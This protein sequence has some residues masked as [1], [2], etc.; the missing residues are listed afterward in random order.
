MTV[1]FLDRKQWG[2]HP[3]PRLG[4]EVSRATWKE[5]IVHHTAG[6]R[7]GPS[8]NEWDSFAEMMEVMRGLQTGRPDLGL[9][10]PYNVVAFCRTN[11]ELVLCEGRGLDRTGAHTSGK[12]ATALGVGFAGDFELV[13]EPQ[14]LDSQLHDLG[15]WLFRAHRDLGLVNLGTSCPIDRDAWGH[16]E[17]ANT[18][19]PGA[20][21][22]G[23]LNLIR[24]IEEETAMD[25]ATWQIVQ[26]GLQALDPPLYAGR[27]VDGIPGVNTDRAVRAFEERMG[28]N[29][30][31]V[32]GALNNPNAGMW[33]ATRELL[34]AGVYSPWTPDHEH[35]V[36][37]RV[38][39]VKM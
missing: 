28:L 35:E 10:V 29:P 27:P 2:A 16:R 21:L 20:S 6:P 36:D 1:R 5:V 31:G 4:T 13:P 39:R 23:R 9:D 37:V 7:S 18:L 12:N 38:G 22:Y 34:F 11:G 24:F 25:Q 32:I 26:A 3:L 15:G 19:C 8:P 14:F 17:F 33:P 30:R